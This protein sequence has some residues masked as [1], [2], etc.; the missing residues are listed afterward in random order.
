MTIY[1]KDTEPSFIN[2]IKMFKQATNI[3]ELR[4]LLSEEHQLIPTLY[5]IH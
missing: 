4:S 1:L 2:Y 3:Q 5:E